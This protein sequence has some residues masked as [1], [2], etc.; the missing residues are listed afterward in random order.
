M[1]TIFATFTLATLVVGCAMDIDSAGDRY[2]VQDP[3]L[4]SCPADSICFETRALEEGALAKPGHLA[5][6]WYQA[7]GGDPDPQVEIAWSREIE[8]F[9]QL[10][11][12]RLVIPLET[13]T[14]PENDELLLCERSSDDEA[15]SPCRG[16]VAIGTATV[17]IADDLDGNGK[18]ESFEVVEATRG[19]GQA[20]IGSSVTEYTTV[21]PAFTPVFADGIE[22][23]TRGYEFE[24]SGRSVRLKRGDRSKPFELQV[25][26]AVGDKCKPPFP[27][28]ADL[29]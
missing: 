19:R 4:A 12:G 27:Q 9:S 24:R 10:E 1:N 15:R 18:L 7:E 8:D 21:P 17:V 20:V 5:V 2:A 26:A 16:E 28:L 3:S 13:I 25:C 11:G 14:M 23:G 22:R 29:R 6:V